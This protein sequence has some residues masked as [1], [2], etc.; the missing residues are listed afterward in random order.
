MSLWELALARG[1]PEL[2]LATVGSLSVPLSGFLV[3]FLD[4]VGVVN[5]E[6]HVLF[7]LVWLSCLKGF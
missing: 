4:E 7:L 5:R 3:Y 2:A 1:Q 6:P